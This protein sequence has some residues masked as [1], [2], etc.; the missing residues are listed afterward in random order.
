MLHTNPTPLANPCLRL[1]WLRNVVVSYLPGPT[2][3]PTMFQPSEY[4][5]I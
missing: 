4:A 2:R 3:T 1:V 5:L